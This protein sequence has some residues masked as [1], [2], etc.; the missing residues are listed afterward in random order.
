MLAP[1]AACQ[2]EAKF[3]ASR[4]LAQF[5]LIGH[6]LL[7]ALR[8]VGTGDRRDITIVTPDSNPDVVAIGAA[9]MGRIVS[10]PSEAWQQHFDPG[11]ARELRWW[12]SGT[13]PARR[14]IPRNVAR[15][16][17]REPEQAKRQMGEV[18]TYAAAGGEDIVNRRMDVG[19]PAIIAKLIADPGDDPLDVGFDILVHR[20]MGRPEASAETRTEGDI[21]S[22][23]EEITVLVSA[24]IV[25]AEVV[26]E[27]DVIGNA[28]ADFRSL[29]Q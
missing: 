17:A 28:L 12:S 20:R 5:Q 27:S 15:R 1:L 22:R 2:L 19:G 16:Y 8:L 11:M 9:A 18:L 3:F 10:G 21:G 13:G 4:Y 7:A 25:L 6:F 26:L 14:Q 23:I 29:N 24:L